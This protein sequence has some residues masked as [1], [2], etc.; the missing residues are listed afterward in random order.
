MC[1]GLL[2]EISQI[3]VASQSRGRAIQ[4]CAILKA[5]FDT[6]DG[7]FKLV[8]PKWSLGDSQ[9]IVVLGLLARTSLETLAP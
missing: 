1:H 2:S 5:L 3:F 4:Y 7:S 9:E 6:K 8:I